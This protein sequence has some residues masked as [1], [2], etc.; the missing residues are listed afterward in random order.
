LLFLRWRDSR[1]VIVTLWFCLP[2]FFLSWSKLELPT[3]YFIFL[4]PVQFLVLGILAAAIVR[5]GSMDRVI[6]RHGLVGLLLVLSA[7]QL[8]S[9]AKFLT[10]I[11]NGEIENWAEYGREYGPPF[12]T[13]VREI[14]ELIRQGIV[15]PEQ[16]QENLLARTAPDATFKY[17]YRATEYI[18][19]NIDEIPY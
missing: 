6:F 8:Q 12:K 18:V 3:H 14:R 13:R 7:Y 4:Y 19:R 17:D 5:A 1:Y 9:A 11:E 2:V 10:A 15:E 16:V